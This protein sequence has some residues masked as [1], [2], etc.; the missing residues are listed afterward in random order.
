MLHR[1]DC[2]QQAGRHAAAG[3]L[4]AQRPGRPAGKTDASCRSAVHARLLGNL[5]V[6]TASTAHPRLQALYDVIYSGRGSMPGCAGGSPGCTP[7]CRRAAVPAVESCGLSRQLWNQ[8]GHRSCV[9]PTPA[10]FITP[11]LQ[12]WAGVRPKGQ[13]HFWPAPGSR[14][15]PRPGR[16][17]EAE[18]R[19][20]LATVGLAA[21]P[22]S[23]EFC[24]CKARP[25]SLLRVRK[26]NSSWRH[27]GAHAKHPPGLWEPKPSLWC[28]QIPFRWT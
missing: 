14:R 6:P 7:A 16:V 26:G 3:R 10:C 19:C 23:L 15:H 12:F 20:R 9:P 1:P 8:A 27:G 24:C 17:C 13:V 4:A 22:C 2:A 18:R 11:P 5:Q 21:V 25:V 28:R